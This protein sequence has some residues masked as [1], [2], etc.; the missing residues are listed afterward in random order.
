[1]KVRNI[2]LSSRLIYGLTYSGS[3]LIIC[4]ETFQPILH[5]KNLNIL[6]FEVVSEEENSLLVL[7]NEPHLLQLLSMPGQWTSSD[8]LNANMV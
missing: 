3:L 4:A 7:K 2:L 1:M 8:S 6:D 5:Q